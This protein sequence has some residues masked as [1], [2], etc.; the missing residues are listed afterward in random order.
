MREMERQNDEIATRFEE[1]RIKL[2]VVYRDIQ[3]AVNDT[4]GPSSAECKFPV[5]WVWAWNAANRGAYDAASKPDAG[6]PYPTY[7]DRR[8]TENTVP[9]SHSGSAGVPRVS[10]EAQ[11]PGQGVVR[12]SDS[13]VVQLVQQCRSEVDE[14]LKALHTKVDSKQI[15]DDEINIIA[16]RAA[17]KAIEKLTTMAYLEIGKGVVSKTLKVIG[18]VAVMGMIY[19]H[20]KVGW[21][22]G[23]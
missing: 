5:A 13:N 7:P 15:T 14:A 2:R 16:E 8:G 21:G 18:I 3:G 6:V 17:D 9:E 23:P 22:K 10:D 1:E 4:P 19:F 20:D 11:A 12:M